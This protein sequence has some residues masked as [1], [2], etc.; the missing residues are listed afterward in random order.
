MFPKAA[1]SVICRY[2][3]LKAEKQWFSVAWISSW[4]WKFSEILR[5]NEAKS[6]DKEKERVQSRRPEGSGDQGLWDEDAA[7]VTAT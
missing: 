2:E 3:A 7:V 4:T 1:W 5:G 6:T